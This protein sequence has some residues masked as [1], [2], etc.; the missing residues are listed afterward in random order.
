M[1]RP[2]WG[3]Y[4]I[5]QYRQVES[6][7]LS[8]GSVFHCRNNRF[9]CNSQRHLHQ[10]SLVTLIRFIEFS[11]GS[12]VHIPRIHDYGFCSI[13]CGVQMVHDPRQTTWHWEL[14]ITRQRKSG[15]PDLGHHSLF[16]NHWLR[17]TSSSCDHRKPKAPLGVS[18][19]FDND[20]ICTHRWKRYSIS[21]SAR[22]FCARSKACEKYQVV[23]T[24]QSVILIEHVLPHEY[25]W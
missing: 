15:N 13:C 24:L 4:I 12:L 25:L 8:E 16:K 5:R 2:Q 20:C 3:T 14:L 23:G 19:C 6:V 18:P 11:R 22:L 1:N 9:S 10:T 21:L 7:R 17:V